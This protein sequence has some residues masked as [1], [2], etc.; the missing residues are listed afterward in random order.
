M[1]GKIVAYL[2]VGK[3]FFLFLAYETIGTGA[4]PAVVS[5]YS[6]FAYKYLI[7]HRPVLKSH[8]IEIE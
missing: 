4:D 2:D 7:E 6:L 3:R 1:G 8:G 5:P